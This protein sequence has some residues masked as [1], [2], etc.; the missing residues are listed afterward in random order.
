MEEPGGRPA[1]L[2]S[3]MIESELC[4]GRLDDAGVLGITLL[5]GPQP[6]GRLHAEALHSPWENG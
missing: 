4:R 3:G 5:V 1:P 2:F 6:L